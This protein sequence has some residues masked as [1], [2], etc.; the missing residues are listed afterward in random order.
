MKTFACGKTRYPD[1][2]AAVSQK[3]LIERGHR[4]HHPGKLRVYPCPACRG[5]HLTK[6]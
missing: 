5:W 4:G 2:R 3:N 1:K 6:H